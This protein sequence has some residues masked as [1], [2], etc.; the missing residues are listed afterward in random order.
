MAT[1]IAANKRRHLKPWD[2]NARHNAGLSLDD[3]AARHNFNNAE[4]EPQID[5]DATQRQVDLLIFYNS[6]VDALKPLSPQ[7]RTLWQNHWDSVNEFNAAHS[8]KNGIETVVENDP[9]FFGRVGNYIGSRLNQGAQYAVNRLGDVISLMPPSARKAA[10]LAGVTPLVLLA[11]CGGIGPKTAYADVK[12]DRNGAVVN[13]DPTKS[14]LNLTIPVDYVSNDNKSVQGIVKV[15]AN[16]ALIKSASGTLNPGRGTDFTIQAS[17]PP[18]DYKLE[19]IVDTPGVQDRNLGNNTAQMEVLATPT[20]GSS[21]VTP[22]ATATSVPATATPAITNSYDLAKS[23]GLEAAYLKDVSFDSNSKNLVSYLASLP[24]QMRAIAVGSGL[25][26]DILSDK[27]INAKEAVFFNRVIGSYQKEIETMKPWLAQLSENEVTVA[28]ALNL[29]NFREAGKGSSTFYNLDS[30]MPLLLPQALFTADGV[31]RMYAAEIE[32][33]KAGKEW[34]HGGQP[35]ASTMVDN[36]TN[37]SAIQKKAWEVGNDSNA[38][39]QGHSIEDELSQAYFQ[40]EAVGSTDKGLNAYLDMKLLLE[41][42]SDA[43]KAALRIYARNKTREG[44]Q[45][46]AEQV[47]VELTEIDTWSIGIP[48]YEVDLAGHD[49]PAIKITD[50]DIALLKKRSSDPLLVVDVEKNHYLPLQWTRKSIV[51]KEWE[52]MSVYSG[53]SG[54]HVKVSDLKPY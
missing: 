53:T 51:Q 38:K 19:I 20:A 47:R 40:L 16:G 8:P 42:G 18:G 36:I 12:I 48:S 23:L 33:I 31:K 10:V 44:Q 43:A 34:G 39:Y 21:T 13:Y 46:S 27:Q 5:W 37:F 3:I 25:L 29:R 17:L 22:T 52:V 32:A 28:L 11:A 15:Y 35:Y 4:T 7:E 6:L 1:A 54:Y 2:N 41:Q 14:V 50:S 24:Q 45:G 9:G 30:E 26:E 49:V